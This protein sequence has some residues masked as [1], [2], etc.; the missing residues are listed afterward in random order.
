VVLPY[1]LPYWAPGCHGVM[2]GTHLV[3]CHVISVRK[4]HVPYPAQRLDA[5]CQHGAEAGYVHHDVA[6]LGL[7]KYKP[8][9]V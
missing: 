3:S 1:M 5:A 7:V 4:E 8:G 9:G 2:Y 6:A